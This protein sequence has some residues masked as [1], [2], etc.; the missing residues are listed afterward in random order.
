MRALIGVHRLKVHHVPNDLEFLGNPVAAVH[1][2]GVAG[3]VEG[4]AAVVAL[5]QRDHFRRRLRLVH[6][7]ANPQRR[8]QAQRD[9]GL[10]V[11]QFLLEQ[12]RLRQR[13][14]EL[15]AIQPVLT[16][17]VPAELRRAHCAP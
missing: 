17:S 12:L 5:N 2:A 13:F 6:Q 8:L 10:H 16:R 11:S 1:V 14:V 15:L 7:P 4:L 3:D 9:L